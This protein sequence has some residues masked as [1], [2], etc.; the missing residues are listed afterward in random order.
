MIAM[1]GKRWFG[2]RI[3]SNIYQNLIILV[4]TNEQ[5]SNLNIRIS[6]ALTSSLRATIAHLRV[7]KYGRWTK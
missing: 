5:F 3:S 2:R 4:S 7:K 6:H 1:Y